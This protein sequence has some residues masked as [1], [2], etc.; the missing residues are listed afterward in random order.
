MRA[1]I[2]CA[3]FGQFFR[4]NGALTFGFPDTPVHAL[5]LIGQDNAWGGAGNK[6]LERVVLDLR[7]HGTANHNARL[8]IVSSRANH[9][10]RPVSRLLVTCLRREVQPHDVTRG[11]HIARPLPHLFAHHRAKINYFVLIF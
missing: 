1:R 9:Q 11:R 4:G 6:D 2:F 8:V 10:G 7:G 5:H 3:H